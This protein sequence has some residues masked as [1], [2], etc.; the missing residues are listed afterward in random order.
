MKT[1]STGDSPTPQVS[2]RD[3]T[4]WVFGRVRTHSGRTSMPQPEPGPRGIWDRL[5]WG[6]A[7]PFLG[8]R[9][10]LRHRVLLRQAVIPTLVVGAICALAVSF[11]DDSEGA[12][13]IRRF[14]LAFVA[15]APVPPVLFAKHYA[16]LA[17]RATTLMGVSE[18]EPYIRSLRQSLV[19]SMLQ[20]TVIAIG[21][22]PLTMLLG[23]VP[24]LGAIW[25]I[26]LGGLWTLYWIVIEAFDSARTLPA[27][28][29]VAT[30]EHRAA[31]D[32]R[33]PWFV[34]MY[35]LPAVPNA[36]A[37]PIRAWGKM[38]D[39][40]TRH[41]RAEVALV[42][43]HPWI[44]AGFSVGAGIM[45]TVPGL[46]LLFRPAL[47]VG[48]AHL[49]AHLEGANQAAQPQVSTDTT[50]APP[51]VEDEPDAPA[52]SPHGSLSATPAAPERNEE[53]PDESPP[54]LPHLR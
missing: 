14:Y 17:A 43:E 9:M 30:M 26:A 15:V 19:E 50:N 54:R 48:A 29:T 11:D 5:L 25:V 46:N 1:Q 38:I 18:N 47:I 13:W 24:V 22:V 39:R 23:V 21:V 45:V 44:A 37:A 41:W 20:V 7:Q 36:L 32:P 52:A 34:R 31:T 4:R 12:V 28:Q 33:V 2:W 40:M 3:R 35:Q 53:A 8:V 51:V 6:F 16:R 10:L 27:G 49:R 42:S